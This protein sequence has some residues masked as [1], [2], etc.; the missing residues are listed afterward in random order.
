MAATEIATLHFVHS[1]SG[2]EAVVIV[3]TLG[4]SVA[5]CL[6]LGRGADVEVVL[7]PKDCEHLVAALRDAVSATTVP[8]G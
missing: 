2:D 3:R 1:D 4:K 5:L 6:S 8:H 7:T